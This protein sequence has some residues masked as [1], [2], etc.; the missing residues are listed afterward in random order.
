MEKVFFKILKFGVVGFSGLLIDF[1]TTWLLKDRLKTNKY[2]ANT[3]G[4]S[5]A[6]I[7]NF[8]LNRSWTFQSHN[9]HWEGEFAKFVAISLI[10]L[11][12]NTGFLYLLHQSKLKMPFY[13][14]K[15]SATLIVFIWNFTANF[16]F[17]FV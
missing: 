12:L 6:V 14:A 9:I 10:G 11:L 4:F 1:G 5:L 7:S 8:L 13:L 15:L 17:T 16:I 2:L 3:V